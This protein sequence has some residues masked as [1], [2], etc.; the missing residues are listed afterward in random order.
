M[1]IP[2]V[3][4]A[5]PNDYSFSKRNII[6]DLNIIP[7]PCIIYIRYSQDIYLNLFAVE[8][9]GLSASEDYKKIVTL[10]PHLQTIFY[11]HEIS[12]IVYLRDVKIKLS[13]D[14]TE[15][16]SIRSQ[17]LNSQELGEVLI[18]FLSKADS[19]SSI[20]PMFSLY[21]IKKEISELRPFLN[22][23]GITKLKNIISTYFGNRGK[24]LALEDMV[25]YEDELQIIQREFPKLSNR[26]VLLCVLI[27]NNLSLNEIA[28][29]TNRTLNSV[30]VTIHRINRKLELSNRN[31][32][33][34]KLQ[35]VVKQNS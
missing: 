6:T 13:N 20:N 19:S 1:D 26:E 31:E 18:L 30:S 14:K 2:K 17:L 12:N 3:E 15:K 33:F 35:E 34:L 28:T 23:Q 25:A 10:N 21:L 22:N 9:L 16:I 5:I 8:L 32:L 29:L 7:Y 27:I 4:I 11:K 24:S